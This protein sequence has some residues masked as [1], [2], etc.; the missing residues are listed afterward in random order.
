MAISIPMA[1]KQNCE[2]IPLGINHDLRSLEIL[3]KFKIGCP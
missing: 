2:E 1:N 3:H